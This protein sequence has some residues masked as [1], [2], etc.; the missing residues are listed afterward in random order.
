MQYRK[1]KGHICSEERERNMH[2]VQEEK[3]ACTCSAGREISMHAV[4]EQK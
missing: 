4:Q 1:I 3:G 2:A